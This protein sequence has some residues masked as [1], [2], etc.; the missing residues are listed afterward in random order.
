MSQVSGNWL[1]GTGAGSHPCVEPLGRTTQP[2]E[3]IYDHAHNEYL[4]ALVEGGILRLSLTLLLVLGTVGLLAWGYW[5]RHTRSIGPTILGMFFA[6]VVLAVHA[7]ADFA[8]HM[9]AVALVSAIGIGVGMGAAVD[10]SFAPT[11]VRSR[12]RSSKSMPI[13]APDDPHA[14]PTVLADS[15]VL[16]IAVKVLLLLTLGVLV[17]EA[18]SRYRADR[19]DAAADSWRKTAQT[20]RFDRRIDL[21]TF[22]CKI[23]PDDAE[24]WADLGIA[25]LD[26]ALARQPDGQFDPTTVESLVNPALQAL[27]RSRDLNPYLPQVQARLGFHARRFRDAETA[28][29]YLER[30]ARLLP[31]DAELRFALGVEYY[32]VG[33]TEQALGEWKR[34]LEL[35]PNWLRPILRE[36]KLVPDSKLCDGAL[37]NDPHVL[38]QAANVRHPDT[39]KNASERRVYLEKAMSLIDTDG[40]NAKQLAGLTA[41]GEELDRIA[42]IDRLITRNLPVISMDAGMRSVIA[43]WYERQERYSEAQE[44]LNWLVTYDGSNIQYQERLRLVRHGAQLQ[45]Q[46]SGP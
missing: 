26:A 6:I 45:K 8:I 14:K 30:A 18:R 29:H 27:R 23:T 17:M 40:W 12:K 7:F 28:D 44:Q 34:S 15:P 20:E 39:R 33:K 16:S 21:Q 22:R 11:V 41:A 42:E 46:L 13:H 5:H 37:P 3:G 2:P 36:A 9:P 1:V 43:T 31:T 4:E 32:R 38:V 10:S 24:A 19:F 25:Y 35:S